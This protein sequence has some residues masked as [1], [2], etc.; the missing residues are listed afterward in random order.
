MMKRILPFFLLL[1]L[2]LSGCNI[3]V[4]TSPAAPNATTSPA[5]TQIPAVT[6]IPIDT[7]ISVGTPVVNYGMEAR[8]YIK[9]LTDIGQRV[10]GTQAEAR[11]AEYVASI[12]TSFGY[13]TETQPFSDTSD[14]DE[15]IDSANV[16]AVKSGRS[17]QEIIVGAHYDSVEVGLG[18]DDNASGVA[19]MLEAAELIKNVS[20]PY[21]I[22]FIAFGA[23]EAGL[24]G[25]YAYLNQMSQAELE[26]TIAMINLDSLAAGDITYVY[27]DEG[28][29]ATL[30]DWTLEWAF[31]N[32]LDLQTIHNVD[33]T[34]EEGN[35]VSD[36]AAFQNAGIPYIYFEA[37]NW[38]LGDQD[39]YT[40]VDPQYGD[41]GKIWHTE[42]DTLEYLDTKFPGRVD[43]H[44][45][46]FVTVLFNILTQYEGSV[47]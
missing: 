33:L 7:Q 10:A 41:N 45:D 46:L 17:A 3:T 22:R 36:Y 16:V 9:A 14:Y 23:E 40:Q 29:Q 24:L 28:Q 8:G 1:A 37:T 15:T 27:S 38:T 44:L 13:P 26:N 18:A 2:V 34:D 11:A 47:Q 12:F 35:A 43:Q 42:D 5:T 20:T 39:G 32:G 21:T 30:R 25:S 6:Q 31:G 19:V 4:A